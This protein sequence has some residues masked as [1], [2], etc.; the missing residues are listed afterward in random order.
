MDEV[1]ELSRAIQVKLLRTIQEKEVRPVGST[2]SHKVDVRIIG[3]TNRNLEREVA[4]KKFRE[5][6][7]YRLNVVTINI[8]P[9]RDRKEDIPI[10]AKYFIGCFNEDFLS[11]KDMSEEALAYLEKYD[12]PGNVRELENVIRHAMAL[13]KGKIILPEDLPPNISVLLGITSENRYLPPK[14]SLAYFEKLAIQNALSKS[15]N[16]RKKAARILRIGEATL[17]RKIKKYQNL[18]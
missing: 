10:L 11:P 12:W 6:L 16:N 7:Y 14:D 1:G 17:Y 4:E 8:P 9:L 5:D 18:A 2:K 13:G 15:G 3:A